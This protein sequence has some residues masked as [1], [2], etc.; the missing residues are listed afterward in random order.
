MKQFVDLHLRPNLDEIGTIE[1]TISKVS[2]LGYSMV[3]VSLPKNVKQSKCNLLKRCCDNYNI[4]FVTRVD[5]IPKSTHELLRNLREIRRKF[6]IVA[7][8]CTTKPVSR[9]AAKD[10]RVDLLVFPSINPRERFFDAAEGKLSSES[11]AALEIEMTSV[12]KFQGVA[13]TRYISC[14]R[15]E[16]GI[17][18]KFKVPIVLCSGALD[19][20]QLRGPHDY[21]SLAML[22]GMENASALRA[23][24]LEPLNI[25]TRNRKKLDSGFVAQG[26]HVL[27]KE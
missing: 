26:I 15:R 7:V 22:F 23:I 6:E 10:Q 2:E 3:A 20:S 21:A 25:V 4:E 27:R 1:N 12:I 16:L 14:L 9:Q 18:N 17:A 19:R 5:L 13:R 24:S 11:N 8:K